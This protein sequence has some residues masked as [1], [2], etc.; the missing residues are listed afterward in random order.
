MLFSVINTL[1][2]SLNMHFEQELTQKKEK[3]IWKSVKKIQM[4]SY[5]K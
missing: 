2:V 4:S 1:Y 3:F 5:N